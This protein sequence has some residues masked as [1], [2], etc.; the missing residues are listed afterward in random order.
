MGGVLGSVSLG[1]SLF[2]A[3][4]WLSRAVS[5]QMTLLTPR[6]IWPEPLCPERNPI[7]FW[8]DIVG[9]PPTVRDTK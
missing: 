3:W 8:G 2:S 4:Q 5:P 9:V 7:N 6:G 1:R